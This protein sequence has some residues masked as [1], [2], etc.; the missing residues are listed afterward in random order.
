MPIGVFVW[1]NPW[2]FRRDFLTPRELEEP[3]M[4]MAEIR[5]MF[6]DLMRGIDRKTVL[7]VEQG[8]E[9]GRPGVIV[10]LSRDR[11]SGSLQVS[12]ADL[13]GVD[14][15]L[16]RRNRMRT[17]LKRARDRMWDQTTHIFST[18]IERPK[19]EGMQ[20]SR[21]PMHGGRGRR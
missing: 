15:D 13:I 11:R 18:K 8:T 7:T 5:D 19:A 14:T 17:A 12:E 4:N 9:P 21:P 20:W 6:A 16:R 3:R 1:R 10:R 2:S